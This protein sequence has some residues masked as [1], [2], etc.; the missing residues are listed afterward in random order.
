VGREKGDAVQFAIFD[1]ETRIDKGLVKAVYFPREAGDHPEVSEEEAYEQARKQLIAENQRYPAG[2]FPA[3]HYPAGT[4]GRPP[5]FFPISFHV[6]I[7]IAVGHVNEERAL[8]TVETLGEENYSE[9]GIV[10]AFWQRVERF[11]GALVSF[12]GRN[13]DLPVLELQALRYGYQAPRYFNEKYGH[14]YRYSEERHYD[15]YDFLTNNGMYRIRGG[16]NLLTR[17]IGLPGKGE[18]DGSMVQGLW[19]EGRLAEIDRYCRHDVIQTYFL[20]LRIELVRGRINPEQYAQALELT[21]S[22]RREIS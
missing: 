1:V 13:F 4:E 5:A 12:N 21:T 8:I 16:F 9:E 15:L 20:F 22:F 19:E 2:R 6:P 18:I 14:R 17:L 3:G 11:H 10:R 7:S